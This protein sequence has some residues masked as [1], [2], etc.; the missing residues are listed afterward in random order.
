MHPHDLIVDE[1]DSIYVAQ[2]ASGA[3]YPIKLERV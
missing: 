2:Y 3:T 1:D